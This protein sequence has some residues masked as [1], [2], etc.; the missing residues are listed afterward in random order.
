[1]KCSSKVAFFDR[2]LRVLFGVASGVWFSSRGP[3]TF[4]SSTTFF[5]RGLRT[6]FNSVA[7]SARDAPSTPPLCPYGTAFSFRFR[8]YFGGRTIKSAFPTHWE[9]QPSLDVGTT[10]GFLTYARFFLGSTSTALGICVRDTCW[11]THSCAPNNS[12]I[13]PVREKCEQKILT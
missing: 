1:M 12:H 5:A 3:C 13:H 8:A 2:D 6:F 9:A 4:T 7:A 10:F 11:S